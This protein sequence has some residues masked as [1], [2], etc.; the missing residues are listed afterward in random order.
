MDPHPPPW[1]AVPAARR[2]RLARA[3][4]LLREAHDDAA[5]LGHDLWQFAVTA[6]DLL[7]GGAWPTDLRW[8]VSAGLLD[9]MIERTRPS[10]GARRFRPVPGTAVSATS[11]FLLTE[12]GLRFAEAAAAAGPA[13]G[14]DPGPP[15]GHTDER[16]HWD[17][18]HRVLTW[19]GG[20]V[21]RFRT[22]APC[23][24]LI[25][26]T[27]QEEGWPARIDDPLPGRGDSKVTQQRLHE[28]VRGLNRGQLAERIQ[29]VRDG[30][31]QGVCWSA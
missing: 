26:D 8:L 30:R 14:T 12:A 4:P 9:H 13:D 2:T 7:A 3:L 15:N 23:Q 18:M 5:R 24:E 20:L 21:K 6:A 31:G 25:L 19:R 27:F 22:P 28:A 1:T 29:F 10:G 16:P 11:C 17:P